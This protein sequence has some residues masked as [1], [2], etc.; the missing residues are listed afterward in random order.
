MSESSTA[1][2]KC[3]SKMDIKVY[4]PMRRLFN[5]TASVKKRLKR[6][7]FE[8]KNKKN[9]S[10][11]IFKNNNE[12]FQRKKNQSLIDITDNNMYN[13]LNNNIK[14]SILKTYSNNVIKDKNNNNSNYIQ[15]QNNIININNNQYNYKQSVINNINT[16]NNISKKRIITP[17]YKS[18]NINN[19]KKNKE[20]QKLKKEQLINNKN[21]YTSRGVFKYKINKNKGHNNYN[22]NFSLNNNISKKTKEYKNNIPE[23]EMPYSSRYLFSSKKGVHN[24]VPKRNNNKI[25]NNIKNKTDLAKTVDTNTERKNNKIKDIEINYR[26][27]QPKNDLNI[28]NINNINTNIIT[29]EIKHNSTITNEILINKKPKFK[30][31]TNFS[32]LLDNNIYSPKK[33]LSRIHSQENIYDS[34]IKTFWK[35]D[36]NSLKNLKGFTYKKKNSSYKLKPKD[37]SLEEGTYNIK[38]DIYPEIKINLR[39]KIKPLNKNNSVIYE[40]T[41][42]KDMNINDT[43]FIIPRNNSSFVYIKNRVQLNDKLKINNSFGNTNFDIDTNEYILQESNTNEEIISS[44]ISYTELNYII[45]L[46]EKTKD[47]FDSLSNDNNNFTIKYC[48]EFINYMYNYNIDNYISNA[49]IDL[50]DMQDRKLFNN[51][52]LFSIVVIYE[53]ISKEKKLFNNL[54]ILVKETIKLIYANIII[55]INYS[56]DIIISQ[57]NLFLEKIINNINNKYIKNNNLYIDD[58]E[59]LLINKNTSSILSPQ[60]KLNYNLNFIIRNIHTIIN[61]MKNSENYNFFMQIFKQINNISFENIYD[62]YINNIFKANIINSTISTASKLGQNKNINETTKINTSK[63]ISTKKLYT[64]VISLDDTLLHFKIDKKTKNNNKGVIQLRPW[65]NEFLSEIK[66]YYEIIAFS[67]GDKKYTE[68]ILNAID[69]NKIFFDNKLNRNNCIIMNNDFVKDISILKK[70]INKI[71]IVDNLVQNYRLHLENGINIKSFYGEINDKI[72]L[73]L[74]KILIKIAK[75]G[76]DTRTGIKY[77]RDDIINKV[78]SNVYIDYYK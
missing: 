66:P 13:Y 35:S 50:M 53:L 14:S 23:L 61:N 15:L 37:N 40:S 17:L 51:Y 71:I 34:R 24:P 75:L 67:N 25:N 36:N 4:S 22:I 16:N 9:I 20:K 55:I 2:E 74:K 73:E 12:N 78:S 59:Y 42:K 31:N 28:N 38:P 68:L 76:G 10:S 58:S 52:F 69:K 62:I 72:L 7:S 65:L 30:I 33:C 26:N 41:N 29:E 60:D 32:S 3:P 27:T 63:K 64:L 70:D 56:K 8:K 43:N 44:F 6:N 1:A 19:N 47:I 57:K 5:L 54:K 11:N 45:I 77:F 18:S 46:L 39:N 21:V 49:I 48:F